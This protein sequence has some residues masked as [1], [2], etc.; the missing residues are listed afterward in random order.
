MKLRHW[1]LVL[2]VVATVALAFGINSL[3]RVG[4][5]TLSYDFDQGDV[6]TDDQDRYYVGDATGHGHTGYVRTAS[7]G[8]I[9]IIRGDTDQ[10][11]AIRLPTPCTT[12]QACP[13]AL[14][15]VPD[16]DDLDPGTAPFSFG[17]SV[18]LAESERTTGSNVVQKGLFNTTGGQWKLQVDSLEGYPS[19]TIQGVLDG[20]P[21]FV[22][23]EAPV[24]IADGKWHD[25]ACRKTDDFVAILVDGQE[26]NRNDQQT[27][28]V[29]N[30][31]PVNI[32]AKHL[33]DDN[34]QFHGALDNVF[35]RLDR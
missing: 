30:A 8:G 25:I 5:Q 22:Q 7:E 20:E 3:A 6:E 2:T 34:D 23:V 28:A 10:G 9:T 31:A 26:S 35:F 15:E 12:D 33:G 19:C 32:G 14:I 21:T 11:E 27:G 1:V 13:K 17:A 24:S 29:A 18:L 16:A 4:T